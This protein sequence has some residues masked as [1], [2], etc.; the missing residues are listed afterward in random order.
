M[1]K[2]DDMRAADFAN[3]VLK[4]KIPVLVDFHAVWCGPCKSMAPALEDL[5]KEFDGEVR[6]VKVDIDAEPD[7]AK[8]YDVKGVPTFLLIKDGE[9]RERLVGGMT[10][11]KMA[12]VL[13]RYVEASQ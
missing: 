5:A 6:I 9:P 2:I 12:S 8:M 7:L 3:E 13:E 1:A 11:G 10:R 4:S